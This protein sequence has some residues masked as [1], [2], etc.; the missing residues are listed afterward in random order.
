MMSEMI[1]RPRS[2]RLLALLVG[3]AFV[4]LAGCIS[5][6]RRL[7]ADKDECAAQGLAPSTSAF[8]DCVSVASDRR[9]EAET[10]Q[11]VRMQQ[12]Q[13]QSME[14]FMHSQSAVP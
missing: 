9:H 6:E 12:M 4:G 3:A 7:A 10:R 13:D 8:E 11:S 2:A 14:N 5:S 1:P